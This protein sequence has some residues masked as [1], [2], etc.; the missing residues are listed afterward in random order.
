MVR[1]YK[2]LSLPI[3]RVWD[4]LLDLSPC[5]FRRIAGK[6]GN[7]SSIRANAQNY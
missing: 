7:T 2:N 4:L 3:S 6:K 5:P 1:G